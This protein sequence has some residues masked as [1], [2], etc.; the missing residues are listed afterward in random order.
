MIKSICFDRN[1][2]STAS[3]LIT[4]EGPDFKGLSL[5][6]AIEVLKKKTEECFNYNLKG[7]SFND[8]ADGKSIWGCYKGVCCM[9]TPITNCVGGAEIFCIDSDVDHI[10]DVVYHSAL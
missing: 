1:L 3:H 2:K 7:S 5:L 9:F 8:V 4:L 6:E 10:V